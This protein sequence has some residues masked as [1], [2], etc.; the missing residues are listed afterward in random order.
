MI[1]APIIP[2]PTAIAIGSPTNNWLGIT[3]LATK[4]VTVSEPK[5][6]VVENIIA[7]SKVEILKSS[8]I[9]TYSLT[10]YVKYKLA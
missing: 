8:F 3:S 7:S 9:T 6:P 4:A 5:Y 2:P 10:R 1:F